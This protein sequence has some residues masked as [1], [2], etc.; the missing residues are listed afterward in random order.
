MK[1][2]KRKRGGQPG[3][4][5]A[6]KQG[7]Y[8]RELNKQARLDFK[9]ASELEGIEEEIAL[10]RVQLNK[11]AQSADYRAIGP[12][13]KA[14]SVLERLQDIKDKTADNH[15]EKLKQAVNILGRGL[16]SDPAFTRFAGAPQ[17]II[18]S[19]ESNRMAPVVAES[20]E[21]IAP[22]LVSASLE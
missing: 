19:N 22:A 13:L 5:N 2:V 12:L 10:L 18:N 14:M 6:S 17:D 8:A 1:P 9:K 21:I 3:N 15:W 7:F 16:Y 4:K 20:P 11:A